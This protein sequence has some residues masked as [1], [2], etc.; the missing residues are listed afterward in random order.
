MSQAGTSALPALPSPWHP[1]SNRHFRD[2]LIADFVSDAGS[3]LQSVGAAWLMTSL[4]S[5]PLYIALIQTAVALPF[6]LL[7]VPAGTIGDIVDRRKL[8][9]G[10]EMWMF[11]IAAVLA[12]ATLAG[13]MTPWLLLLLTFALS[14][15]DAVEAPAWRATLPEIVTKADLPAA[16]SLNGVEFNLA[17][18]VGP[19]LAGLIVSALGVGITFALN[20]FSFLGVMFVVAKWKRPARKRELPVET[21]LGGMAAAVRYVRYSPGIRTLLLRSAILMFLTSSFWALL[22]TLAKKLSG[23][24]IAYGLLL[25]LFGVGAVIGAFVLPRVRAKFSVESILAIATLAFA[26]VLISM[27]LL[28][29]LVVLC[30]LMLF[31]GAAWTVFMSVFN[32]IAQE[33]APDWVRSRVLAF[34]LFV[35]QGSVA[36]GSAAWGVVATHS[37]VHRT[38]ALAGAS[39]AACLLLQP[40]LRLP[41]T[42]VDLRAWNHWL[43]PTMFQEPDPD[44]GPVLVTVKYVIDPA[45]AHDFLHHI[46]RYERIR[47]RDGATQWGV[48]ADTETPNVYVESFLVDSWAEHERQHDRFTQADGEIERRVRSFAL[49][50]VEVKHYIHAPRMRRST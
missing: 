23:S 47:R 18:A 27:A 44:D 2:L 28:G 37:D 14:A 15:S 32:I 39:T 1:L 5:S 30:F 43:R 12:I 16:L 35:F 45:K 7:A 24:P 10:T 25:G 50:P 46:Y 21:F 22:P 49:K 41:S 48:F 29:S 40:V 33:L 6:F 31:G 19:G 11:A 3:F 38:F 8:I 17:R 26:V 4:T 42:P 34:Y 36:G 13:T 9:L 20:T